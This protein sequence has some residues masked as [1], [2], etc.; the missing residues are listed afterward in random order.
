MVVPADS[1]TKGKSSDELKQMLEEQTSKLEVA[2]EEE[3]TEAVETPEEET[4][5][6]TEEETQEGKEEE[7]PEEKKEEP[8]K[9]LYKI[10]V[11]GKEEE[12]DEEKII[13]Y[14]QKGRYLE[15]ERAKDKE[16]RKRFEE[17]RTKVAQTPDWAKLNEQFVDM[18]QKDPLGTLNIYDDA[19]RK[20]EK[21]AEIE[22]KR[23]ERL[24]E[25]EK[26]EVPYWKSIKP[27][28]QELKDRGLNREEAYLKAENDFL[29]DLT[30]TLREKGFQEGKHKADLKRKAEM[31][32]KEKKTKGGALPSPEEINKMTSDQLAK[33]LKYNKV[34]G[35]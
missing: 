33:Y 31:P 22:E 6:S 24:F 18:L 8:K 12:L 34:P 14:A 9:K 30:V 27:V 21:A 19:K 13:E 35:W 26:E 5:T 7:T 2:P 20:S 28:Y 3:A 15:R 32:L 11:E 1:S 29:K 4:E 23:Q 25:S 10:K 16:E 17:D